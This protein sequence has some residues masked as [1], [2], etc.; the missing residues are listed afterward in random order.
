M[1]DARGLPEWLVSGRTSGV[2]NASGVLDARRLG[3][4]REGMIGRFGVSMKSVVNL[5]TGTGK[6]LNFVAVAHEAARQGH[7]L[8]VV[9]K[10]RYELAKFEDELEAARAGLGGNTGN[11]TRPDYFSLDSEPYAPRRLRA[12]TAPVAEYK[13]LCG[14]AV[15]WEM[16][17]RDR[18]WREAAGDRR[19]RNPAARRAVVIRSE[20]RCENPECLLPD[21]PYRTKAGEPLLE[22]DHIDDHAS[23][24]RDHPAAMIAL[25]PNCHRNK[26]HG[27]GQAELAERLRKVAADL[28]DAWDFGVA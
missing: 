2:V 20:G 16:S 26:T 8:T 25:C 18:E 15:E 5:P 9:V 3:R 1:E 14:R 13:A 6:T 23:G 27:A 10:G 4:R 17:G 21:L 12:R 19:T 22:V 24:G 7:R 11:P 28:H